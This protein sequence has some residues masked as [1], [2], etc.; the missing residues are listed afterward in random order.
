MLNR[1]EICYSIGESLPQNNWFYFVGPVKGEFLLFLLKFHFQKK[2]Q[3]HPIAEN[4]C[5]QQ[6]SQAN[7][8]GMWLC[9]LTVLPS[10][11]TKKTLDSKFT[12]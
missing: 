2:K 12:L 5:W 3:T 7:K 1:L 6:I 11:P 10:Y 4:V 9:N 8:D